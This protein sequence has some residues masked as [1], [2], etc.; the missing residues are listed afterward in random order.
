M[1]CTTCLAVN[2]SSGNTKGGSITVLLTTCLTVLE[3][4]VWQLTICFYLQN[5]QIQ[6][7][8]TGGQWYSD[9]SPFSNPWLV[10]LMAVTTILS[11]KTR[12]YNPPA[13]LVSQ[14]ACLVSPLPCLVSPSACLVSQPACLVS[15]P[16]C[17]VS[18]PALFRAHNYWFEIE[19]EFL[20]TNIPWVIYLYY[21]SMGLVEKLF[22]LYSVNSICRV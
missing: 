1:A 10:M 9:T 14:P 22:S 13:C 19:V 20:P 3:S 17:L 2:V 18:L 7:S 4:A 11:D 15:Q 8:E 12:T 16:A 21:I 6:T 5:R